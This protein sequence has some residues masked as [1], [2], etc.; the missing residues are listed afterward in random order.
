[1]NFI[2]NGLDY[3]DFFEFFLVN[4][5]ELINCFDQPLRSIYLANPSGNTT[6]DHLPHIYKE[7]L[8]S[9]FWQ[10]LWYTQRFECL[11]TPNH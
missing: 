4:F 11:G 7:L 8:L 1:M 5:N 10:I 3:K 6:N 2:F 9:I